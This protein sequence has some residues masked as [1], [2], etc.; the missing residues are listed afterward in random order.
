MLRLNPLLQKYARRPATIQGGSDELQAQ[1]ATAATAPRVFVNK[2]EFRADLEGLM[3]TNTV[4]IALVAIVIVIAFIATLLMIR[5]YATNASAVA[6]L[7]VG[8]GALTT[9]LTGAIL[10]MFKVKAQSDVLRILSRNL[11]SAS[12]QTVID[13]LA[14]RT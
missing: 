9:A 7:F 5:Q 4:S 12:F 6:T 2:D 13:L 10:A 1:P 3:R 14:K 8:F 11:D